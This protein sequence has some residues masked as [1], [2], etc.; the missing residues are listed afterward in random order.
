M[1]LRGHFIPNPAHF[2]RKSLRFVANGYFS[3]FSMRKV[4]PSQHANAVHLGRINMDAL[5]TW[6][7]FNVVGSIA[8]TAF[9]LISSRRF[10]QARVQM[11]LAGASGAIAGLAVVSLVARMF[12]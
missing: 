6:L 2:K 9:G 10:A 1:I 11:N 4:H 5:N 3:K 8:V 12:V 7:I